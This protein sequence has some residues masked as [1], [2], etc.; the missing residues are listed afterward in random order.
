MESNNETVVTPTEN[1]EVDST[2]ADTSTESTE[3]QETSG[4]EGVETK[5]APPS[6]TP[7]YK[8]KVYDEEKELSDPLLKSLIKDADSEKKVKEIAQK[9]L[10][11]DTVKARLDKTRTEAQTFQQQAQPIIE[12]YNQASTMLQKGDLES[13]FELLNIPDNKIFEYAVKKAEQAQLAP[14]AQAQIQQQKQLSRE[15]EQ[16]ANQNQTLQSQQH[17]QLSNFRNQELNWVLQRPDMASTAQAFDNKNGAGAFRK[18]V[19]DQGLAHFAATQGREDLSAEQ[20]ASKVMQMIGAFVQPTN[21]NGQPAP[22]QPQL[23]QQN[24]APPIIPNVTGRGSSPVKKQVRSLADL[25]QKRD[26]LMSSS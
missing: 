6:Y 20:A 15:R 14:E 17:Q 25:K 11:F 10:G 24:G 5:V 13:F 26:E 4:E 7:D 2:S 19:I 3:T 8:L 12:Y 23:I 16:L 22:Q 18:L 1:T 9:Y 21:V